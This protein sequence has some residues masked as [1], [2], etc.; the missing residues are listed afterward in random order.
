MPQSKSVVL[1]DKANI[2]A[3]FAAIIQA[4]KMSLTQVR[5]DFN[6][7]VETVTLGSD[8]VEKSIYIEKPENPGWKKFYDYLE[9]SGF[10]VVA[11]EIKT[12]SLSNGSIKNKA[13]F[14]VEIATDICRHA[15]RRD[16]NEVVLI[17]GDSDFAYLID[18]LKNIDIKVTIVSSKGTIS[19]ELKDRA[20]RI[21]LLDEDLKI[22]AV[23][24]PVPKKE[25]K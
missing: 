7:L 13:N 12:I 16:C 4:K 6:K 11:K 14:D 25:S 18:S 15:W 17:S 5:L 9:L 8:L 3:A 20:D 22:E 2:G 24:S 19:R 1:I 21:I 23:S 10:R